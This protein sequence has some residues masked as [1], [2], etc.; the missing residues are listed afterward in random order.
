[1]DTQYSIGKVSIVE[2]SIDKDIPETEKTKFKKPTV[3]EIQS[4]CTERK[5]K[6]DAQHF[7]D[8]NEARNWIIDKGYTEELIEYEHEVHLI[9]DANEKL[10]KELKNGKN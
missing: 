10:V 1:M 3:K 8:Y 6:I 2:D 7:Y 5:N 9:Y 4:Y